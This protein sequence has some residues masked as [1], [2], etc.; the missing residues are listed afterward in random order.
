[1]S[2]TKRIFNNCIS[3]FLCLIIMCGILGGSVFSVM[4]VELKENNLDSKSVLVDEECP[5]SS[6][7]ILNALNNAEI[8]DTREDSEFIVADS[9]VEITD[10]YIPETADVSKKQSINLETTSGENTNNDMDTQTSGDSYSFDQQVYYVQRWLNQEYGDVE[11]F[12]SVPENGK[13]GWD[14]IYGLLRALQH[15]LG[16]TSLANNFGSTTSSYYQQNILRRQDGVTDNKFAILQ[17]ALWCKGYSPGYN[18]SEENG[19]IFFNAVFDEDVENAVKQLQ[20]DAGLSAPDGVVSLNL[21]KALM[22][23]DSFKLLSSYGGDTNIRTFQQWLNN[24]YEAYT[25]LNPCDGVYGRNTNKA[26]ILALQAEE[27]LPTSIANGNFGNTT[28]LC[29]PEIPYFENDNAARAYPGTSD[30]EFYA[31]SKIVN[32]TKLMQF[33]LYVNGFGDGNFDGVFDNA[34]KQA[35]REF[36]EHYAIEIT[37]KADKSTWLS[38]F[39]S[40]GDRN[41]SA[42]A[43]DCAT[44]LTQPKAEA[45]YANG[46]RYIG[47]YLTGTYNGGI[48]KALTREEAEIILNAGLRFFP[49]YQ[50]SARENAYFTPEQGTQDAKNAIAAAEALGIPKDTIIYFAVDFDAMDYQITSNI[51]PYFQAVHE[52]ISFSIYK[53]GIYGARNVCSRVS[54]CGYAYSS[55]VG[56]MS[57]GFSGN[58][59]FKMPSNWAFDQFTDK[60]QSGNYLSITSPDGSFAIDKDGFSGRDYG[61]G[62]LNAVSSNRIE[63]SDE[64]FGPADSDTIY[65]PTISILGEDVPLFQLNLSLDIDFMHIETYYDKDEHKQ[66]FIMG[67]DVYEGKSETMG[68]REKVGKYK[69]AYYNTKMLISA[70]GTNRKVFNNLYQDFKGSLYDRGTKVG[71]DFDTFLVAYM[72]IDENGNIVESGGG[73]IGTTKNSISYP[74]VPTV[75]FKLQIEG[76]LE[77]TFRILLLDSGETSASGMASFSVKPSLGIE[78]NLIAAEAYVGL[79]G[80]ILCGVEYP[81]SSIR[82][83]F[84]AKLNASVFFE[85]N[86]LGWGTRYDWIFADYNLYPPESTNSLLV[87]QNDLQFIEPLTQTRNTETNNVDPNVFKD[88]MQIYSSPQIISLNNNKMFM[89]YIDDAVDRSAENRFLLMY[90]IYDGTN[91]S[92]PQP[93]LNDGTADFEPVL[94]AD[95]NGGVHILWQN[96]NTTFRE[97]VTLSEMSEEMDLYYTHWNGTS[98]IGTEPI[99]SNNQS[100]E[101]SQKIVSSGNNIAIVWSQNSAN[102]SLSINGT[103]TI[104]RKQFTDGIWQSVETVVSNLPLINSMDT[105]YINGT[106]IIVYSTKT[107]N[108]DTNVN[109]LELFYFDGT[110]TS[111]LTN[112]NVP[113]YSVNLLNNELYWI[114]DGAIVSISNGDINTKQ[115]LKSIDNSISKVSVISNTV[116]EK[117]IVWEQEDENEMTFYGANY[118]TE[119]ATFG[120][121]Y[122]LT[123][124]NGVVRGW[125]ACMQPNG[126]IELA[127]CY[128]DYLDEPIDGRPYGTLSLMQKSSEA[129]FDICVNPIATYNG[130]IAPNQVITLFTEIHNNG[131]QA[132][133]QLDATIIGMNGEIV[134]TTTIYEEIDIGENTIIEIPFLLPVSINRMD[135]TIK[136]HPTEGEDISVSDNEAVFSLGFSDL[137][138]ENVIET[139]TDTDRQL[140]IAVKNN[141]F[142]FIESAHLE[143][144]AE[145]YDG[146]LI[147]STEFSSLASNGESTFIFN[148]DDSYSDSTT[149]EKPKRIFIITETLSE[150]SDY[151]NNQLEYYVYPD[152]HIQVQTGNEG[153]TV[154]GSGIYA[155]GSTVQVVATTIPGFVFQGWYENGVKILN[156]ESTYSF[157]VEKGRIL[158]ARFAPLDLCNIEAISTNNGIVDTE[159]KYLRGL[160]PVSTVQDYFTVTNGGSI[161]Q[162]ANEY[163]M[164]N[165]TGTQVQVVSENGTVVDVYTI[166][167]SGD[168]NGDSAVDF[169]DV[170]RINMH[171]S[172]LSPLIGPYAEAGDINQDGIIDQTDYQLCVNMSFGLL[173]NYRLL[174]Q[175]WIYVI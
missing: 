30:S 132:T 172:G 31:Y 147:G 11:G 96:A 9:S 6:E 39:I 28:Q 42:I 99:T 53:T 56:D 114:S 55:F 174:R 34:A 3:I 10:D 15:E 130:E 103:N 92:S 123:T 84:E 113:D 159:N 25:G 101:M 71:F 17:G 140:I 141:G 16:I 117:T 32:F 168:V 134:Q 85:W 54:N 167:V 86:V 158:E 156:A 81:Y 40:C 173:N 89:A 125:D 98:F 128:A 146:V 157:E 142:D 4:A 129:F 58:L 76:T 26:L 45:L 14:T 36:Q 170:S 131:S 149:S 47:R 2:K 83:A 74:I 137:A 37:G 102:S 133:E 7:E 44:I 33:A 24:N 111:R 139:R 115:V 27:G 78:S 163:G 70:M 154:I 118:N 106:N 105:A 21:M 108:D 127:F 48:S 151:G 164:I 66:M 162:V 136:I 63:I 148:L 77:S 95:G 138:I 8:V 93:V 68:T 57:T 20:R 107:S 87:S 80:E 1:M 67:V 175:A 143:I 120:A 161:H 49:I 65:G 169:F 153:G 79:S 12:G 124:D 116:G 50:T 43:A 152:Y 60:D 82:D 94:C 19:I 62:E 29:C 38:L 171:I 145:S 144:R 52:E 73:I 69:E 13:T 5:I 135:Y 75:Y 61:V 104:Y 109:D 22:S 18:I 122:P 72:A 23:M 100:F 126:E 166:I 51:I 150:E 165:A 112:D 91:W 160:V 41:R 35:I 97:G 64:S 110:E 121:T 46:Y 90:S 155:R 119:T 88:N 59:G